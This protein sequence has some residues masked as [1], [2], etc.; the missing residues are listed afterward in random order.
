METM[1]NVSV[2]TDWPQPSG[3]AEPQVH[4]DDS[5]LHIR[6]STPDDSVAI[7]TFPLANVFQFGSPND[8][9]LGGH[10]LYRN[11]LKFYSIHRVD[12][13]SWINDLEKRNSVDPQHDRE[14]FLE[15]KAHYVFTFQN[16]T[17]ECVVTEGEYW[18][19]NIEICSS[20]DEADRKWEAKIG[21]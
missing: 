6:Y 10:P 13:S 14:R 15:G 1:D 2:L 4:A 3:V 18:K 21:A 12:D 8:E 17:L 11:G 16:S 5:R 20:A 19:P 9:A 7:I